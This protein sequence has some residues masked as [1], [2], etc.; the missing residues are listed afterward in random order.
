MVKLLYREGRPTDIHAVGEVE[1]GCLE[2]AI[3]RVDRRVRVRQ[4][5]NRTMNDPGQ[6]LFVK[7]GLG[8]RVGKQLRQTTRDMKTPFQVLVSGGLL[9]FLMECGRKI[10]ECDS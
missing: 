5:F 6:Y 10:A 2:L 4:T 3:C 8:R 1:V 9:Q 7:I